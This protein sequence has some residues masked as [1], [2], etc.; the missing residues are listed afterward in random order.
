MSL[1]E[2][3]Q[4]VR[5]ELLRKEQEEKELK[6]IAS[7]ALKNKALLL[8]DKV[9]KLFEPYKSLIESSQCIPIL[10][11]LVQL[12]RLT[13]ERNGHWLEDRATPKV[14]ILVGFSRYGK[15]K[16]FGDEIIY[17]GI[18]LNDGFLKSVED[19]K[20]NRIN[21]YIND[22]NPDSLKI[23]KCSL[24]LVWGKYTELVEDGR[25]DGHVETFGKLI[26]IIFN[27]SSIKIL[28]DGKDK[29]FTIENMNKSS[30]EESISRAYLE[31]IT[32]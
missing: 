8:D 6:R 28:S 17:H 9:S 26:K 18:A 13:S 19:P 31:P 16:S 29:I 12:E 14:K 5:Q 7:E 21:G 20:G 32:R 2:N 15:E 22:I 23:E 10:E 25:S 11:E 27:P 3:I 24:S 4:Q 1:K 30:L